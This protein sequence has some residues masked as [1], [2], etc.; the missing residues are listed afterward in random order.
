MFGKHSGSGYAIALEGIRQ[1]TLVYGEKTP[2]PIPEPASLLT[3]A[4]WATGK[5]CAR[6]PCLEGLAPGRR[7]QPGAQTA[8]SQRD[9]AAHPAEPRCASGR[10]ASG[11]ASRSPALLSGRGAGTRG[12]AGSGIG[13]T[14]TARKRSPRGGI[15][16]PLGERRLVLL[17][18][19]SAA[20][21]PGLRTQAPPSSGR[22][23]D[24]AC[25]WVLD[26]HE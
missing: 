21:R 3:A 2:E 13:S 8:R 19:D 12:G 26:V 7:T 10:V 1:K 16:S 6:V 5:A 11:Y 20:L 17:R 22:L 23:S 9:A 4:V 25:T 24:I 15:A 14:A 18:Q